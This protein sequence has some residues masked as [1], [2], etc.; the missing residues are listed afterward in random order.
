MGLPP[1]RKALP[2]VNRTFVDRQEPQRLFE[3]WAFAIP[4]DSAVV[5]VFHGPGG[6]GKTALRRELMRKTDRTVEPSFG[7]LR[8]AELDLADRGKTDPDLLLVWIRNAF[9]QAGVGLPCFDLALA[10]MWEGTRGEQPVPI[11]V[12]PLL[13]RTREA[14]G[15]WVGGAGL[16]RAGEAIEAFAGAGDSI[17]EIIKDIPG[18]GPVLKGLGGWVV[19]RAK[20]AWLEHSRKHLQDLYRDG[21]LL[22]AH[23]LSRLLP[24]MLAQD[25]NFHLANHP[26]ERF[27]LFVDEYERVFDQA[28]A[29]ARWIENPF[30]R[31]M[32][33]FITE[34][35][36]LLVVF[37]MREPLPWGSDPEWRSALEDAHFSLPGLAEVDGETFL[38]AI[39]IPDPAVRRAM[40]EGAR[41]TSAPGAPVYPLML[42][43]QVEHWCHL[44]AR[45][46]VRPDQ[47]AV[48][49][50]SFETRCGKMVA[51]VLRNYDLPLQVTLERLSVAR[52]FD[53][54]AFG[55]IV[56][57]FRTGLPLDNFDQVAGLSFVTRGQDGF[58]AFHGVIASAIREFLDEERRQ[59]S[60][61][62][63]FAHFGA[64]ARV[65]TH[66][67]LTDEKIAALF[68]AS[69]LRQQMGAEGFV[70]WLAAMGEPLRAGARYVT[71]AALWREA[72]DYCE[73]TLGPDHRDVGICLSNIAR[74]L[75][76]MGDYAGAR[77]LFAR[78]LAISERAEGS[79]H[80]TTG[81]CL[82]DLA[83]L[84]QT[85]GDLESARPLYV[86]ALEISQKV[87]GPDHPTTAARMNDLAGLFRA[88]GN[89]RDAL[90]LYARALDIS[91]KV[92]G[93]EGFSTAVCMNNIACLFG[94]MGNYSE[95]MRLH[96]RALEIIKQKRGEKHPF[97]GIV[98]HNYADILECVGKY[99]EAERYYKQSLSVV[100]EN[101]G[102][103]HLDVATIITS[104]SR[105]LRKIGQIQLAER[106]SARAKAIREKHRTLLD[107]PSPT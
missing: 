25:L 8:R 9:A 82:N 81:A 85:T 93:S 33:E 54:A 27:V 20:R 32:R 62:A 86:R 50:D 12:N 70:D 29:G 17:G 68:E 48:T 40:I 102:G 83:E 66:F 16:E 18:L 94:V 72:L 91:E 7:F 6:Q 47:F 39:P 84:L 74:R 42:S 103:E 76:A 46:D 56:E 49:A 67:E 71:S 99:M 57:T 34:T 60:I 53:R 19:D 44:E 14:A 105:L 55:C 23:E 92:H 45:K 59:S 10:L 69:W 89:Y 101:F 43:L 79:D 15:E 61:A 104:Y 37:F 41:E 5:R 30:D 98:L 97:Y 1:R 65:K 31:H 87:L 35:N 4:A 73:A 107:A 24:C 21:V 13:A 38:S 52:R 75:R 78:A 80:P 106:M 26:D 95:S 100:E 63:L 90:P 11:L 77:P 28:G 88:T 96:K 58:V 36:G 51:R 64:R 3:R 22:P 2:T